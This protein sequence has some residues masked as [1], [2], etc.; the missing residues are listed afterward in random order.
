ML[1]HFVGKKAKTYPQKRRVSY[2]QFV[3]ERFVAKS[4]AH[5][6]GIFMFS[7]FCNHCCKVGSAPTIGLANLTDYLS[8]F[9][10]LSPFFVAKAV[11]TPKTVRN[12]SYGNFYGKPVP[13]DH[14]LQILLSSPTSSKHGTT[15]LHQ[16][17][18]RSPAPPLFYLCCCLMALLLS[19]CR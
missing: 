10:D 9:R 2:V 3:P 16:P 13:T 4:V 8:F 7:L 5:F 6:A 11:A 17:R 14:L 12:K 15:L 1:R 19:P 18:F